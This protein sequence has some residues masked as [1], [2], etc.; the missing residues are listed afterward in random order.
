MSVWRR[1]EGHGYPSLVTTNVAERRAI[2]RSPD[3]AATLLETIAGVQQQ[4]G[5]DLLAWVIMPDHLHLVLQFTPGSTGGQY[6][7]APLTVVLDGR[8][9]A[10]DWDVPTVSRDTGGQ[11]FNASLPLPVEAQAAAGHEHLLELRLGD[12]PAVMYVSGFEL[13]WR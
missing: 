3:P 6:G 1:F 8:P 5:I 13:A 10:E 9:V 7:Y 4:E 2:L 11:Y 12:G